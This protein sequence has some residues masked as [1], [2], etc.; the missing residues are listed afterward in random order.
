MSRS[1]L[2]LPILF[3]ITTLG[4]GVFLWH[5]GVWPPIA[6]V[7]AGLAIYGLR[8]FIGDAINFIEKWGSQL[9]P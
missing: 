4:V 2:I 9:S 1:D 5:Y 6:L 7:I 3:I 8:R